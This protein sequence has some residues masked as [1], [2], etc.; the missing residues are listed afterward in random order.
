M[1]K[2]SLRKKVDPAMER[3]L[4][5]QAKIL[6]IYRGVEI[7]NEKISYDSRQKAESALSAIQRFY[8]AQASNHHE[9]KSRLL[10]YTEAA[11]RTKIARNALYNTHS[12]HP[13]KVRTFRSF[14][15]KT[16][17]PEVL[18]ARR[19]LASAEKSEAKKLK[20]VNEARSGLHQ[21][22]YGKQP[23]KIN[24]QKYSTA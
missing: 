7:P 16:N 3:R 12:Q 9:A 14:G 17:A 18:S 21:T 13:D 5:Q 20:S 19:M 22:H 6:D 23:K 8:T 1:H 11:I 4:Q 2:R 24:G 10:D 15:I